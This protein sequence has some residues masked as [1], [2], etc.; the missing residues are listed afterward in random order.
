MDEGEVHRYIHIFHQFVHIIQ[1]I[2][3]LGG[4]GPVKPGDEGILVAEVDPVVLPFACQALS[5]GLGGDPLIPEDEL[6]GEIGLEIGHKLAGEEVAALVQG[7][8]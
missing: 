8:F 1:I 7:E 6:V 2:C 4:V 3:H 5:H